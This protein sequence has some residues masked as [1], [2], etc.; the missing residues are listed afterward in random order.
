M[1][2]WIYLTSPIERELYLP[3]LVAGLAI[4]LLCAMLSVVVVLKR[5]A[6]IGQGISHAAFG[7]VGIAAILGLTATLSAAAPAGGLWQ[8]L[9]VTG[10]CLFAAI[11]VGWMSAKGKTQADTA[12][13]I[14]LVGSMALGAVLLHRARTGI[15]WESFLFGSIFE[16][17]WTQAAAAWA[18]A[19]V[20]LLAAWW[21]RRPLVFWA[22]DEPSAR[23]FGVRVGAMRL[24]M[25][26][27]LAVATV[28]AMKLVGVVLATALLV[29]PGA[30]ALQIS[31]RIGRVIG[32]SLAF[33]TV[34]LL[35]GI[36]L[37]FEA[38]LPPG[39]SVVIVLCAVF[40]A[41][42]GLGAIKSRRLAPA[43]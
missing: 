36:V 25:M 11:G 21:W 8:F 14:V 2:T 41:A 33:V 23:A 24:L 13:G 31:D 12:I 40:A 18:I 43:A 7:G 39:P 34:G 19:A 28:T 35:G 20:S 3:G 32:L 26:A 9:V 16:S 29:L 6:F 4:A 5:L 17:E 27:L 1:N 22:F 10:F 15:A 37:S 30:A 38:N 42:K